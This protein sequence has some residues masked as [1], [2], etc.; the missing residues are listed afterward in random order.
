[1][2]KR[3]LA[4]YRAGLKRAAD[5]V[6]RQAGVY[7]YH[8]YEL[9]RTEGHLRKLVDELA[10]IRQVEDRDLGQPRE[11]HLNQLFDAMVS[12]RHDIAEAKINPAIG[13]ALVLISQQL[14]SLGQR[15]RP[16]KPW[17]EELEEI[18]DV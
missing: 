3:E 16:P 5:V 7:D 2:T 8:R 11:T 15:S 13:E 9:E 14:Q 1:M 12:A 17:L 18:A 6:L 10:F 4:Y